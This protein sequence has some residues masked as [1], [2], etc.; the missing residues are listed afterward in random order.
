MGLWVRELYR[1][2]RS[3]TVTLSIYTRTST[4]TRSSIS[5]ACDI[6]HIQRV[7]AHNQLERLNL[8]VFDIEGNLQILLI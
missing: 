8:R 5:W 3:H 1:N 2:G 6:L 4:S 7:A